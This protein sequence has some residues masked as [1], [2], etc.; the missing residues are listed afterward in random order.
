[1]H[2]G[3]GR[4]N[5][6]DLPTYMVDVRCRTLS[7]Y[8]DILPFFKYAG[9]GLKEKIIIIYVQRHFN[10]NFIVKR[11][12]TGKNVCAIFFFTSC[13][14]SKSH[15]FKHADPHSLSG[16]YLAGFLWLFV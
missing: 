3:G 10:F 16:F 5:K 8:F 2:H 15:C 11:T 13:Y 7:K 6:L 4:G 12:Y 1:M 9:C 14:W